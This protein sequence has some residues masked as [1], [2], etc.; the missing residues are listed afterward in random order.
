VIGLGSLHLTLMAIIGIWLW[1]S[2]A[3]FESSQPDLIPTSGGSVIPLECTSISLFGQAIQLS[4]QVLRTCSLVIYGFFLA[5]ILNLIIPTSLFLTLYM[6]LHGFFGPALHNS[7]DTGVI[8]VMIGLFFLLLINAVFMIDTELTIHR[9][10]NQQPGES[11]WT[12]GQTL[13]LL[14]LSLPIRD[15]ALLEFY[16]RDCAR[17]TLQFQEAIEKQDLDAV[18]QLVRKRRVNVNVTCKKGALDNY[19]PQTLY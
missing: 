11:Q 8:S 4:S 19:Q 5:P 6:G 10:H 3:Q 9:V 16:R 13:A 12:F 7:R 1:S 2:P 14:L 18:G 17:L 15:T